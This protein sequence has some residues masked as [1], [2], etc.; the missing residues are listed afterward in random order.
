MSLS[1]ILHV[2]YITSSI[3]C[4][5]LPSHIFHVINVQ[6]RFCATKELGMV[7]VYWG[8]LKREPTNFLLFCIRHFISLFFKIMMV[9]LI[10]KQVVQTVHSFITFKVYFIQEMRNCLRYET[11][12]S[13]YFMSQYNNAVMT[14]EQRIFCESN[15]MDDQCSYY[16][17]KSTAVPATIRIP[18]LRPWTV[19]EYSIGLH[20]IYVIF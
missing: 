14:K 18:S 6:R 7:G 9:K 17:H 13:D 16:D 8:W 20:L 5:F 10:L 15:W 1:T 3:F 19:E 12:H 2:M 11:N 4:P